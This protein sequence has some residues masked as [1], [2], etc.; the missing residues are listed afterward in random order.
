MSVALNSLSGESTAT[1]QGRD[2]IK[3]LL[4]APPLIFFAAFA[5]FPLLFTL[6]VSLHFWPIGGEHRFVALGNYQ[7][8]FSDISFLISLRNNILY[9]LIAVPLQYAL[10]FGVALLIHQVSRGQRLVRLIAFMPMM[11][12]PIVVGFIWNMLFYPTYG[13]IDFV[14]WKI[15][16]PKVDWITNP[17]AAFIS[18]II[19]D[20]W[21]W[22]PLII[23]IM[24]GGLRS[25]PHEPFE[26]ALVDGASSWRIFWDM[27]FPMLLP[28]SVAAIVLR[29][30]EA[31]KLFDI[32]L[33]MTGGGPGVSTSTTTLIAYFTGFR[34]ANMG[35]A[36]AMSI[37]LLIIVIAFAI[38]FLKIMQRVMAHS[39]RT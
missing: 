10:G 12:T 33:L 28:Y 3:H 14:L 8:M 23:L 11:L 6:W 30:I 15:G 22:T 29:A 19:T 17:T 4:I 2:H 25:L 26:S 27:T 31:F 13:P 34:T 20:T 1:A 37:L 21:Q 32:V 7:K 35:G 36:A 18:V 5:I 24:L 9:P 38:V 39:L 16:L